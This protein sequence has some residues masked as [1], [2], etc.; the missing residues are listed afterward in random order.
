M[1]KKVMDVLGKVKS[2]TTTIGVV[3]RDGVI[4]ASDTRAT[5]GHLVAHKKAK[6]IHKIDEHLGMTIAGGLADAQWVVDVLRANSRLYR[7]EVG[8]PMPVRSAAVLVANLLFRRRLFP[9]LTQLLVG[10]HD[11]EGFHVFCLDP[12][13]SLTEEKCVATGS[14]SF[15]A[16]GVLEGAYDRGKGVDELLPIVVRAVCS[17]MKRDV[18]SGDSF[19]VAVIT[20]QGYRE[21]TEEEKKRLSKDVG[22]SS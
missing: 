16:Y 1:D 7:L 22:W 5:M 15:I 9:L 19:D 12:W 6:K 13:G 8:R 2:G 20:K 18:A 17:A 3:C 4:L 21:L 11:A 14:G 10:G